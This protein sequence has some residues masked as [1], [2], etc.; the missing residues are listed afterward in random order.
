[1]IAVHNIKNVRKGNFCS[2]SGGKGRKTK[3]LSFYHP[4]QSL[5]GEMYS[6]YIFYKK[7]NILTHDNL[8]SLLSFCRQQTLKSVFTCE[9]VS[10][11]LN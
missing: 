10:G 1:M 9:L 2:P 3:N 11:V 7:N 6:I 8:S 4:K 5:R